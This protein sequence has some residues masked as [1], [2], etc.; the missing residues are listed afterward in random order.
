MWLGIASIIIGF[1]LGS[2]PSAYILTKLRKG[3]DIREIDRTGNMGAGAVFRQV[4]RWEGGLIAAADIGKG[5]AAVLVAQAIGVSTPWV[6]AASFAALLGHNY[7]PYIGFRGGQG[8][9]TII[10]IFLVLAP[11]AMACTLGVLGLALLLTRNLFT[12]ACIAAPFLAL[13]IWVFNGIGMVFYFSL[14]IIAYVLFRSRNRLREF[15][16]KAN[17]SKER[18]RL[19]SK[20]RYKERAPIDEETKAIAS[21][22]LDSK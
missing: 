1:L 18:G 2:F 7:P 5:A 8:V 13:F 12:M 14:F 21:D 6:L 9:A 17:K 3:V 15:R 16:I 19:K 20:H 11:K 22:S 4:G 10:G